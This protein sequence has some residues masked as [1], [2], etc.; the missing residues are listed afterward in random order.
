MQSRMAR[1]RDRRSV[2]RRDRPVRRAT[3]AVSAG[4]LQQEL[5]AFTTAQINR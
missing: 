3:D 1:W 5:R 2:T 4:T